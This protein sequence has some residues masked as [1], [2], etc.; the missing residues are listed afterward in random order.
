MKKFYLVALAAI[1]TMLASCDKK[2]K[3]IEE[4]LANPDYTSVTVEG[5]GKYGIINSATKAEV[6][7]Q[8]FNNIDYLD[9]GYFL[10]QDSVGY[11]LFNSAGLALIP[12]QDEIIARDGYFEL[13]AGD[14]KGYYFLE[15]GS[16]VTGSYEQLELDPAGNIIF[17]QNGKYGILNRKGETV[18]PGE[19]DQILWDGQNYNV[20]KNKNEIGRAHV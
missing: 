5:S 7:P 1:V 15:E 17:L 19:Y 6:L 18:I 8:M 14:I 16:T 3:V 4:V 12:S 10:T 20:V 9:S 11:M 13:S 2:P